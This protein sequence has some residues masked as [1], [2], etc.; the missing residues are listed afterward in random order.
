MEEAGLVATFRL[1]RGNFL[2][3]FL[4]PYPANVIFATRQHVQKFIVSQ[5][6][7]KQFPIRHGFL[8]TEVSELLQGL[9]R[10]YLLSLNL[11][12]RHNLT[13]SPILLY[14]Q[15]IFTCQPA[16]VAFVEGESAF[17]YRV[18]RAPFRQHVLKFRLLGCG[19]GIIIIIKIEL[20]GEFGGGESR[21][22][23]HDSTSV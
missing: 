18:I 20:L 8:D 1:Y 7:P 12:S 5:H 10:Q 15:S 17:S 16:C 11:F 3:S 2:P 22:A 21:E 4:L 13:R 6:Y 9:S 19:T 23:L 14:F